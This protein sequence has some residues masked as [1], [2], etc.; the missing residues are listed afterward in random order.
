METGLF[1][2]LSQIDG[3]VTTHGQ[4]MAAM[5]DSWIRILCLLFT[6]MCMFNL[7]QAIEDIAKSLNDIRVCVR[8]RNLNLCEVFKELKQH[9]SYSPT[10][11]P[12]GSVR[13]RRPST[14]TAS[15]SA[16]DPL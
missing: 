5:I 12:R 13:K 8:D 6:L 11:E 10:R 2:M 7:T 16:A 9:S 14:P 3:W 15:V 1:S 4:G